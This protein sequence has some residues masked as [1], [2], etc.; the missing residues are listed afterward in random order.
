M[1]TSWWPTPATNA[2]SNTSEPE[3]YRYGIHGREFWA[4]LT[5]GP[6]KYHVRLKFAATRGF[7]T[8]LN[9]FDILI[10]GQRVVKKLDVAATAGGPNRAVDLV[11]DDIAP[12][13]GIIEVRFKSVRVANG[14]DAFRGEAFVQALELGPGDG[15]Q[16]A[17]PVASSA[18]EPTGNLLANPGFEETAQGATMLRGSA[19]RR[20]G[21]ELRVHRRGEVLHLAGSRLHPASG[22][23]PAG[24]PQRQGRHPHAHRRQRPHADCAGCR[25]RAEDSLR[26]LRLGACRGPSRQRIRPRPQTR[27][28]ESQTL[29]GESGG[30]RKNEANGDRNGTRR[31]SDQRL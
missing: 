6:G 9:C 15:G 2:I 12:R 29:T 19:A 1:V 31:S 24:V 3:L 10:N 11:F 21:M 22:V 17:P 25:C 14:G 28:T 13:N 16:G 30:Y 27:P 5:V 8:R 18:P 7:D 26:R 20:R 23:G 4:N